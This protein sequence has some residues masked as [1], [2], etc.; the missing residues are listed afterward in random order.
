MPAE[1]AYILD[2]RSKEPADLTCSVTFKAAEQELYMQTTAA[3]IEI[4]VASQNSATK[5]IVSSDMLHLEVPFGCQASLLPIH[6]SSYLELR[7]LMAPVHGGVLALVSVQICIIH[8]QG[9]YTM[10]QNFINLILYVVSSF[11]FLYCVSSSGRALL[12]HPC[13]SGLLY[14]FVQICIVHQHGIYTVL[15]RFI[16]FILNLV[17]SFP[18]FYSVSSGGKA[19]LLYPRLPGL[20]GRFVGLLL[21][22]RLAHSRGDFWVGL[23]RLSLL[24]VL[25]RFGGA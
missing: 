20:R 13:L 24:G 1:L 22:D 4:N 11:P 19:L 7:V 25:L 2:E 21:D 3:R 5:T 15:Q 8:Q 14:K 16:N 18:F 12:L 6:A 10:L 23:G 17:C 9:I